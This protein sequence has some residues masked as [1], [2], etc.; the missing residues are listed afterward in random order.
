MKAFYKS[1]TAKAALKPY[2]SKDD[3]FPS[4]AA[5]NA[6]LF[7]SWL[8]NPDRSYTMQEKDVISLETTGRTT[9]RI[10]NFLE[11]MLQ[12]FH[13]L[14]DDPT[15]VGEILAHMSRAVK[16][17]LQMQ[18]GQLCN[19]IL[20]RRDHFIAAA[21]GLSKDQIITL[22]SGNFLGSKGIF[23][24]KV[25]ADINI[26][27]KDL[28]NAKAMSRLA[29]GRPFA[30]SYNSYNR[31]DRSKRKFF[32]GDRSN[33][34][35]KF[36]G[37]QNA[38]NSNMRGSVVSSVQVQAKTSVSIATGEDCYDWSAEKAKIEEMN[39]TPVGGRLLFTAHK[40]K[41]IGASNK[42]CRWLRRGYRLPFQSGAELKA[43]AL[44][45]NSSPTDRMPN[46][47]VGTEKFD[48]L[49]LMLE[50]LLKKKA[51]TQMSE[52]ETGFF[53][54]VFLRP[55]KCDRSETRLD[56][57]W[58]LI[59]D[60]S[61]LNNFLVAKKFKMETA[62][63]IRSSIS[64]GLFATSIDLT[65][66]YHH[67]PI[68][69][70]FQNFL[71]FQVGDRKFK[72]EAMPFGLCSAPQVF[73]EVM[74]PLK[75][76]ARRNF[77]G[78]IFQYLDDW[79][80]LDR[81][82][83]KVLSLTKK[84]VELCM[85][86]GMLVNLG[87]S[88]LEP[89]SSL[90]HLGTKWDFKRNMVSVPD[91]KISVICSSAARMARHGRVLISSAESLMGSLVSCE[92]LVLHGRINFR[93]F[94]STV[95]W[96]L[97]F[98]RKPR[99]INLPPPAV[100]DLLWWSKSEIISRPVPCIPPKHD[101][102]IAT[103][104]SSRGWGA[105]TE[106]WSIKGFWTGE[107]SCL[108]INHKELLAVLKTL[109]SKAHSL[110]GLTVLFVMDNTTSVSYILKQGGTRSRQMTRTVKEVFSIAADHDIFLKS[111]HIKGSLNV[112]ADMLSRP[113][114]ALKTEWSLSEENFP[115]GLR[116]VSV[117]CSDDRPIRKS[118]E[119]TA[120]PI[121]LSVSRRIRI[122]DRRLGCEL[123]F[124]GDNAYPPSTIMSRPRK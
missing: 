45:S 13:N 90:V 44:F 42:V 21:K 118:L 65:D 46:Y 84:F 96:N 20:F 71:A 5:A 78:Y 92:K 85:D 64:T 60:V 14:R 108:H 86:Q 39:Q 69:K 77:G 100:K 26:A 17:S 117:G 99:Y 115:L 40:W 6:P 82:P 111:V 30:Q 1:K 63:K 19:V 31:V 95:I 57:R 34:D 113:E 2:M 43:R 36:K 70:N 8:P 91:E 68:H 76:F 52:E 7:Y 107:E 105:A 3:E 50:T 112:L 74:T 58:R 88:H 48:A 122:S 22:R 38:N 80:L 47:A 97:K 89:T 102:T 33:R 79:L 51:I 121:L 123:A 72:Y 103:D 37:G 28:L 119:Q 124:R 25:L 75:I 54:L 106:D 94:Q 10:L 66:A 116:P 24:E 49:S 114:V 23:C 73:T 27:N 4:D 56:K 110:K 35:D 87:K 81:S 55:K 18:I 41:S 11:L 16:A 59:L 83:D 53:N 93:S 109:Q 101:V 67:I 15:V 120:G 32:S 12:A 9:I 104:A 29:S 61:F 62:Q 98:G